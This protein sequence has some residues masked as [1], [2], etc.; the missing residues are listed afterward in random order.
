VC[1]HRELLTA[2]GACARLEDQM[3]DIFLVDTQATQL[4]ALDLTRLRDCACLVAVAVQRQ[5]TQFSR[6]NINRIPLEDYGGLCSVAT[7]QNGG[8]GSAL[9]K[10]AEDVRLELVEGGRG[11]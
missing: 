1:L 3:E 6:S 2:E 9:A 8:R 11:V 5:A 4:G 10:C 7:A